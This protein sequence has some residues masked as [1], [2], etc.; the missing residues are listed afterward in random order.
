[1]RTTW[2]AFYALPLLEMDRTMWATS[3][4]VVWVSTGRVSDIYADDVPRWSERGIVNLVLTEYVNHF[5]LINTAISQPYCK[6]AG[7]SS[8]VL[9]L[10]GET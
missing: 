7:A 2:L 10:E 9:H 1:M 4:R 5:D 8:C 6:A 3:V